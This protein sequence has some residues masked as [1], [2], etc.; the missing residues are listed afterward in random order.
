MQLHSF[1]LSVTIIISGVIAAPSQPT[2]AV[3]TPEEYLIPH[4]LLRAAHG[5]SPLTWSDELAASAQAWANNCLFKHSQ[6]GQNLAAG[7]GVFPAAAGIKLWA[8]EARE[9]IIDINSSYDH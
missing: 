6:S 8:D 2:L 1:L 7:A 5:A 9:C 3:A 4:N